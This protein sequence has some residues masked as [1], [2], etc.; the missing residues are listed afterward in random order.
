MHPETVGMISAKMGNNLTGGH[1]LSV[2]SSAKT[3]TDLLDHLMNPHASNKSAVGTH[4]SHDS[5]SHDP[6]SYRSGK[7][8]HNHHHHN[9]HHHGDSRK[10]HHHG[11][12]KDHHHH[13]S[14]KDHQG[15]SSKDSG[16]LALSKLSPAS[17]RLKS[18]PSLP[19]TFEEKTS[20][21][22]D[23]DLV[24]ENR[25]SKAPKN[26]TGNSR[27]EQRRKSL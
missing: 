18:P 19:P 2:K 10:D 25:K 5:H 7:D 6:P 21:K 1:R 20:A 27:I 24:M 23:I 14:N 16:K 3:H 15:G 26:G 17:P 9:H 13:G 12:R 4:R 8:D 11:S 22:E